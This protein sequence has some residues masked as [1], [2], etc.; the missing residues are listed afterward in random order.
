[1]AEFDDI[2]AE[3]A[4]T[5]ARM[6]ADV[7]AE[8]L[9]G[10]YATALLAAT[11]NA[12]LTS[13]V[14]AELDTVVTDVLKA[15]P[16]FEA[17]LASALISH[18]EK[19]GILDRVFGGQLSPLLLNF[20][21]VVSR[22]G[23]LDCLRA[24]RLEAKELEDHIRGRIRVEVVTA[25]P[26]DDGLAESIAERL[27]TGLGAEP[28]ISRTV[29]PSVIGGILIRVGDMVYDGSVA[30]QLKDIRRQMIDRS[31]HEIQSRRDS[32]SYPAGN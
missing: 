17:I 4:R 32:F 31:V 3:D 9:A 20:L 10:I 6:Q 29:D 5:A 26:I 24:I 21:K 13:Q 7:G 14:L 12:G 22:H 11:E 27:R 19:T 25:A 15:H 30:N 28:L 23:R 18:D 8:H 16:A 2:T 1:M